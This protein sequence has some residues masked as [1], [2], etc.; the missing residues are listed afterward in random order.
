MRSK[1]SLATRKELVEAVRQRYQDATLATK[2]S[3]LNEFVE[4]TGYHRKHAVRLLGPSA[5]RKHDK[6]PRSRR[7][8]YDDTVQQALIVLWETADRICGKRL[9]AVIPVLLQAM[10]KH[11]HLQ[12][13][14]G[15]RDQLLQMSAATMDRLLAEPRERVTGTRRRKG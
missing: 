14:T 3:I 13:T 10:E 2:T 7:R 6:E 4:V 1:M 12:L 15:V 5:G 11:G 9:K 8:I